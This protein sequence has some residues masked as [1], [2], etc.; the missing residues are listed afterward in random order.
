V[1]D[2]AVRRR[3]R[4]AGVRQRVEFPRLDGSFS[5]GQPIFVP[6]VK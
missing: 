2:A 5:P 6:V 1:V 4:E 3:A